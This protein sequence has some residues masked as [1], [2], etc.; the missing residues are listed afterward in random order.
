[1]KAVY[2]Y[3]Q[4]MA[5]VP[6]IMGSYLTGQVLAM[7]DYMF[8]F[9]I[10]MWWI[11]PLLQYCGKKAIVLRYLLTIIPVAVSHCNEYAL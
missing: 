4:L 5:H 1:M 11:L 6:G 10:V 2:L 3:I 8:P 7:V 9:Y